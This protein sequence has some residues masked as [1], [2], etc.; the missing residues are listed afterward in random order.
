MGISNHLLEIERG[1]YKNIK[2]EEHMFCHCSL[3]EIND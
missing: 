1:R 2:K 3:N